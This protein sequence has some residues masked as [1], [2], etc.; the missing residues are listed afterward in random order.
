MRLASGLK[1]AVLGRG[2]MR[3]DRHGRA[4]SGHDLSARLTHGCASLFMAL[5]E[6]GWLLA[7]RQRFGAAY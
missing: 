3:P 5:P 4:G 1:L 6:N 2:G 7:P